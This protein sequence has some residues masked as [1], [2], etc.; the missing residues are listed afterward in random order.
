MTGS[1][2]LLTGPRAAR[3][4]IPPQ[5]HSDFVV[6]IGNSVLKAALFSPDAP[7]LRYAVEW[8]AFPADI[9]DY[10]YQVRERASRD[11]ACGICSVVPS[12]NEA[13]ANLIRHYLEIQPVFLAVDSEY[14]FV[15]G[16]ETPWSVGVD[17]LC[18]VE[19]ALGEHEPPLA[20]F[21]FGTALAVTLVNR[22]RV[23]VGGWIATG[24]HTGFRALQEYAELLRNT[25]MEPP[26]DEVGRNTPS[27]ISNGLYLLLRG[28]IQEMIARARGA[29]GEDCI[30]IAT[31][32][33]S[34][35]FGDLFQFCDDDLVLKGI[36]RVLA[37]M[38]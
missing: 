33:E 16:Y 25:P 34:A 9:R 3:K 11:L 31:G 19:G 5:H 18:G 2:G 28:G 35:L 37:R 17:R 14:S 32:G 20:V 1:T 38:R 10:L 27:A 15:N 13:I 6:D 12:R 23:L 30:F 21:A 4:K 26:A 7:P 8:E 36:A 24:F 22:D 29:L